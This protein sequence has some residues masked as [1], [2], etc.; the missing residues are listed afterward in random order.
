LNLPGVT[1]SMDPT[2]LACAPDTG[3][4]VPYEFVRLRYFF[5]QRL[6]VLELT[7]EQAY[8]VGKQRFHNQRLHG[9]GVLCGLLAERYLPSGAP[10][11]TLLRVSSGAAVDPCG[12]EILVGWDTCVDLAAWVRAH[13][14]TNPDLADPTAAPAQQLWVGVCYRECPS[15]PAPAPRDPC[16]CE[17]TGCEHAR[18]REGFELRLLTESQLPPVPTPTA[19]GVAC[20]AP[21]ADPCLVLSRVALT[22]DVN[23]EVTDIADPDNAPQER[24]ALWSTAALQAAVAPSLDLAALALGGGPRL[25]A[26]AFEG[27]SGADGTLVLPVTTALD[28]TTGDPSPM[29]GDPAAGATFELRPH[30]DDGTWGA[31]IAPTV[32]WDAAGSRIELAF[33]GTLAPGRHRLTAA[34]D[35]ATPAVDAALRELRPA[36]LGRWL[37]LELDGAGVLTLSTSLA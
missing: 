28:P 26:L 4:G 17:P 20:P 5:G 34:W 36:S 15:D 2:A 12:R 16:G 21:A 7:D 25:G 23:G 27:V 32:G 11:T 1:V 29:L 14:A 37:R 31:P 35:P 18:V 30:A 24:V 6:G 3:C 33:T 9:A 13:R 8:V 10:T 19:P 22:Y